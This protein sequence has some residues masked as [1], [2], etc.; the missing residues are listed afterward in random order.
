MGYYA[1]GSGRAVIS[2]GIDTYSL[3]K[4]LDTIIEECC[5]EMAFDICENL[6]MFWENDSHWH[7]E[8]T[9]EFLDTLSEYIVEGKAVYS[10]ED[11]SIWAYKF[12]EVG[13]NWE[14]YS[15]E[16]YFN[17]EEMIEELKGRGYVIIKGEVM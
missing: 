6:I 17:E 11:N 8:G 7:E 5:N 1:K 16:T 13:G 3:G 2:D 14:E 12:N 9:M 10:G 4:K 15:G